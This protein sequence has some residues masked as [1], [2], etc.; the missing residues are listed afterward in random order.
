MSIILDQLRDL[1]TQSA[2][3]D[4]QLYRRTKHQ[5]LLQSLDQYPT[6]SP[7]LNG[8]IYRHWLTKSSQ[9]KRYMLI[10]VAVI[11]SA[12]L[13]I[14]L[15]S[16][17]HIY[18]SKQ[19]IS[20]EE[21]MFQSKKR[22]DKNTTGF[23]NLRNDCFANSTIQALVSLSGLVDYL[24][25]VTTAYEAFLADNPVKRAE[26]YRETKKD[27]PVIPLH[28]ALAKLLAELQKVT[29]KVTTI[30][31]W[32]VLHVLER[33]FK[34]KI[35][36]NQHDAHELM[37]L[38]FETLEN[39]NGAL[40]KL[41]ADSSGPHTDGSSNASHS[42]SSPLPSSLDGSILDGRSSNGSPIS[43]PDGSIPPFP[44]AGLLMNQLTCLSCLGQSKPT[45]Q[46]F[47]ILSLPTPHESLTTLDD[48]MRRNE[49]ELIEEY[50]CLRC[51]L[52]ALFKA[53]PYREGESCP[54]RQQL[55][56][57]H[58]QD[59]DVNADIPERLVAY[60][61]AYT[62]P[63]FRLASVKT[64]VK[65]VVQIVDAPKIF[66]LHLSRSLYTSAGQ[67][68]RNSCRVSFDERFS[69]NI[70]GNSVK[71]MMQYRADEL[72]VK[73]L[74]AK[75]LTEE[76]EE[77]TDANTKVD[78]AD[79]NAKVEDDS[80]DEDAIEEDQN[81]ETDAEGD[82]DNDYDTHL[83]SS[84]S[85]YRLRSIIKHQGTHSM[86]H[87]EC[88]RHKP[89]FVKDPSGVGAL[90]VFPSLKL[91]DP[92]D[93]S[94]SRHNRPSFSG[95]ALN[96]FRVNKVMTSLETPIYETPF[97]SPF[98]GSP[99]PE[100]G[101]RLRALSNVFSSRRSSVSL[102]RSML[103]NSP[104]AT[105]PTSVSLQEASDPPPKAKF[106]KLATYVKYPY[107]RISDSH[108]TEV[109]KSDVLSET[110]SVYMLFYQKSD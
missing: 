20:Q 54:E 24:N 62:T 9:Q 32:S 94:F 57:L 27:D 76:A 1:V 110:N 103:R 86:G 40:K 61:E 31:A 72:R 10:T 22:V 92:S 45:F 69:F 71:Q 30:S 8:Q 99:I 88:F 106:K 75:V 4:H 53:E 58:T 90:V 25:E 95:M 64:T 73:A 109:S 91:L 28:V 70:N 59:L 63:H 48:I 37:Q 98:S 80:E 100:D 44:F 38:I 29:T 21:D 52:N 50:G 34:A 33:I 23:I 26:L 102:G 13:Y 66:A 55:Y 7:W 17:S 87:Y 68:V 77:G 18:K 82:S 81:R 16:L 2:K 107:W 15:P 46:H 67:L 41:V 43:A 49:V 93:S 51:Q 14:I 108:V 5:L 6:F 105:D 36:R 83:L 35:S 60:M 104:S 39:E 47:L 65:R 3:N 85:S 78:D 84:R 12:S 101:S 79:E 74:K 89:I 19:Q 97:S 42:D 96:N 11:A 56:V